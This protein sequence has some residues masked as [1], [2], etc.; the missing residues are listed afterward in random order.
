MDA[1]SDR[2]A[3]GQVEALRSNRRGCDGIERC[4]VPVG[5]HEGLK[6]HKAGDDRGDES[7]TGKPDGEDAGDTPERPSSSGKKDKP[8]GFKCKEN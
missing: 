7:G 6:L 1:P 2:D 8:G 3:D 5:L 4:A